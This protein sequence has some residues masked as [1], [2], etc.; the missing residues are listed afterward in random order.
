[1][2]RAQASVENVFII[3]LVLIVI[4]LVF[5]RFID[6]RTGTLKELGDNINQTTNQTTSVLNSIISE[7]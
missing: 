5:K 2:R 1:M 6:P 4:Y 3:A 7:P